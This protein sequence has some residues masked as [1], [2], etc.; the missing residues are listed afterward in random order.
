MPEVDTSVYNTNQTIL[1]H[2][3][4]TRKCW[5]CDLMIELEISELLVLRDLFLS[6]SLYSNPSVTKETENFVQLKLLFNKIILSACKCRRKLA[7]ESCFNKY[8][9]V[10]Q[11][12]NVNIQIACPQCTLKYEFFYPYNGIIL[13]IFDFIDQCLNVGSTLSA[14]CALLI[15]VYWC[16]LSYG[17]LTLLQI[18]GNEEGT[19]IIKTTSMLA[20]ATMFPLIPI[21]L[22]L[23]RFVP[24]ERTVE[25]LFPVYKSNFDMEKDQLLDSEQQISYG[26]ED[27][28]EENS[29]FTSHLRLVMG[30]LA[31]P[32][33]AVVLEKVVF[34]SMGF[35]T[36]P[37]SIVRISLIG[38]AFVGFKGFAKI[39]YSQKKM[40]EEANKSI[41]DY[42]T[43]TTTKKT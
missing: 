27:D 20:S 15:S 16:S 25:R 1:Q 35:T 28:D 40:W 19:T 37:A 32:T 18:Y 14:I 41:Q 26:S 33:I 22:V 21:V 39:F 12:G 10:R 5:I 3:A 9:D 8:I 42:T 7:H 43:T 24:W 11:S 34:G 29:K 13:Q 6:K 23:S 36:S 31:L 2:K 30:G 4:C 17:F 38:L